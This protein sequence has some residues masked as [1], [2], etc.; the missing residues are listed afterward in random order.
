MSVNEIMNTIKLPRNITSILSRIKIWQRLL[1]VFILGIFCYIYIDFNAS[2]SFESNNVRYKNIHGDI[3]IVMNTFKRNEIM[4]DAISWYLR[5][6]AVKYIY[7]V[8]SEQIPPPMGI[9]KKYE[10]STPNV[11]VEFVKQNV[12][13]LN[14]RFKPLEG[15]HTNAILTV[16]DDIRI[17]CDDLKTGLEVF[18]NSPRTIVGYMPRI[19]IR[20]RGDTWDY[21]CW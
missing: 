19:H 16:D 12:D 8:W 21:R 15:P 3:T 5:C 10:K 7:I 4:N 17:P 18:H 2:K 1:I 6:N 9:I 13:S 11:K 14:S 20:R